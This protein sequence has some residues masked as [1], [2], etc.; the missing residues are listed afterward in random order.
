VLLGLAVHDVLARRGALATI[1]IAAALADV[2]AHHVRSELRR[3][4]GS[5]AVRYERLVLQLYWI[6]AGRLS[7]GGYHPVD[8]VIREIVNAFMRAGRVGWELLQK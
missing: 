5:H 6:A 2:L 4:L 8:F 1:H 3:T 7:H